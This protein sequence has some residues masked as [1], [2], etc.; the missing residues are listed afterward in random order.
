MEVECEPRANGSTITLQTADDGM[1][2]VQVTKDD[3]ASSCLEIS[4]PDV[5]PDGRATLTLACTRCA[6]HLLVEDRIGPV[7][8][9]VQVHPIRRFKTPWALS[10]RPA[11][12][13]DQSQPLSALRLQLEG[14]DSVLV[15]GLERVTRWS[16]RNALWSGQVGLELRSPL[17]A[18]GNFSDLNGGL[19]LVLANTAQNNN[20]LV[21]RGCR[22]IL[23]PLAVLNHMTVP[24]MTF[25]ACQPL[26]LQNMTQLAAGRYTDDALDDLAFIDTLGRVGYLRGG[27]NGLVDLQ[28]FDREPRAVDVAIIPGD[29]G[30]IVTAYEGENGAWADFTAGAGNLPLFGAVPIRCVEAVNWDLS[31]DE[32]WEAAFC[33]DNLIR[34]LHFGDDGVNPEVALLQGAPVG[35]VIVDVAFENGRA[36]PEAITVTAQGRVYKV[37][38]AGPVLLDVPEPIDRIFKLSD[39][40]PGFDLALRSALGARMHLLETQPQTLVFQARQVADLPAMGAAQ[41]PVLA[42]DLTANFRDDLI[43]ATGGNLRVL[44]WTG[45]EWRNVIVEG[46]DQRYSR[47]LFPATGDFDGDGRPGGVAARQNAQSR[48]WELVV[49]RDPAPAIEGVVPLN[50]GVDLPRQPWGL[51]VGPLDGGPADMVAVGVGNAVQI[52]RAD[53]A[54]P[55]LLTTIEGVAPNGMLAFGRYGAAQERA[56]ILMHN[57]D[58][59]FEYTAFRLADD[60]AQ[61]IG[62]GEQAGEQ[63]RAVYTGV[64]DGRRQVVLLTDIVDM[65]R[66]QRVRALDGIDN[67]STLLLEAPIDQMAV[68]DADGDL[69]FDIVTA[70]ASGVERATL[71]ST[72]NRGPNG[73]FVED[74]PEQERILRGITVQG[75]FIGDF[76]G[77]RIPD[78]LVVTANRQAHLLTY[79]PA[80]E[81]IGD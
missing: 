35:E 44:E 45:A 7:R 1:E 23:T 15:T 18:L 28:A 42:A 54:N 36:M 73:G 5:D 13:L 8:R 63:I 76:N 20:L 65:I 50:N 62:Q 58:G 56:L 51:A 53:N 60:M 29:I 4:E 43:Y 39:D 49:D 30:V 59:S 17:I 80:N 27:R 47:D 19:E 69:Q 48:V 2:A 16:Q 12:N 81:A 31:D 25:D 46:S 72:F 64:V 11:G 68:G 61:M 6:L 24:L 55:R 21:S 3:E 71:I 78:R 74:V 22:G 14:L 33:E 75:V 40:R 26:N 41:V 37:S 9:V 57:V 79:V 77:D 67:A 66:P 38:Q 10:H 70:H 34:V 52:Y 32:H